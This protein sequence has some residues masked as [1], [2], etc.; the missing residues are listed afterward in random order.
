MICTT[1]QTARFDCIS[2]LFPKIVDM[3]AKSDN[4]CRVVMTGLCE[5]KDRIDKF[6]CD[7]IE[8]ADA[9]SMVKPSKD[10]CWRLSPLRFE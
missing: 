9:P 7:S 3:E 1:P 2:K 8:L 6:I 10:D 4:K 5:L